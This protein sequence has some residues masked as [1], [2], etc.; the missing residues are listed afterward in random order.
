MSDIPEIASVVE[1]L[2]HLIEESQIITACTEVYDPTVGR[3]MDVGSASIL[4]DTALG[5]KTGTIMEA[6]VKTL[7]YVTGAAG[8]EI[9]VAKIVDSS[10]AIEGDEDEEEGEGHQQGDVGKGVR[11]VAPGLSLP[12]EPGAGVAYKRMGMVKQI[13]TAKSYSSG[14]TH[15]RE[16]LC[17]A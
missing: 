1:F 12:Q 7:T 8:S 15:R 6:G 14:E 10:Y 16:Y 5:N 13:C 3:L 17:R 2:P 9:G 11:L 4:Q